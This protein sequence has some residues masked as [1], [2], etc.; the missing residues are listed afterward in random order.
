MLKRFWEGDGGRGGS[1]GALWG[2]SSRGVV[3]AVR[4]EKGD[5]CGSVGMGGPRIRR[6]L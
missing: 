3:S 2:A 1:V 5:D 6:A 4:V